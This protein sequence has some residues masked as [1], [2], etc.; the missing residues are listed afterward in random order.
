MPSSPQSMTRWP[1]GDRHP[2]APGVVG[3]AP[4]GLG[5]GD[6]AP[7]VARR[8]LVARGP[9]G[10]QQ[11]LGGD[12]RLGC[13]DAL[14]DEV[15]DAVCVVYPRATRARLL[16]SA[17][18]PPLH[19]ALDRLVGHSAD[20][21][22]SPVAA[23][24]EIGIDNVHTL[25]CRLHACLRG[26]Q[27]PAVSSTVANPGVAFTD[28]RQLG[29]AGTFGWPPAGT[30]IWPRATSARGGLAKDWQV[31]RFSRLVAPPPVRTRTQSDDSG[32]TRT[33]DNGFPD[34]CF[35]G[36]ERHREIAKV[37]VRRIFGEGVGLEPTSPFGQRFSSY[38]HTTLALPK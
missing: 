6:R 9:G 13:L 38:E 26:R 33:C 31:R 4:L 3:P 11:T 28:L 36:R 25:P 29:R 18:A 17:G 32:T 10:R 12:A 19:G 14:R 2:R 15:F 8:P 22:G 5:P 24:F 21:R 16:K 20:V 1:P 27:V 7:E 35:T 37:Q 23:E 34:S 30:F